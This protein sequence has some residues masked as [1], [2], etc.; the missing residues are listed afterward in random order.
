MAAFSDDGPDREVQTERPE[1]AG[2]EICRFRNGYMFQLQRIVK[3]VIEVYAPDGRFKLNLPIR[4]PGADVAWA[5]D[6]AVDS[7]GSFVVGAMG[8]D[9]DVRHVTQR[10]VIMLDSNGIQTAVIDTKSFWPNR[11]AIAED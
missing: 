5:Q 11:V 4:L 1:R 6:V 8:G 2:Q 9:G 7:D 10:G 3:G